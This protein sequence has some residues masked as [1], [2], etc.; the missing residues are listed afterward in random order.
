MAEKTL[1]QTEADA[2]HRLAA[3]LN[4]VAGAYN[5]VAQAVSAG[6]TTTAATAASTSFYDPR[7][8][9]SNP[10]RDQLGN[11]AGVE[12]HNFI[13][14]G[15]PSAGSRTG[16]GTLTLQSAFSDGIAYAP[17]GAIG[18]PPQHTGPF[19]NIIGVFLHGVFI[20]GRVQGFRD[21]Y[22]IV[23][24]DGAILWAVKT[25][26]V[27]KFSGL[28]HGAIGGDAGATVGGPG[29]LGGFT[30]V[31]RP[32]NAGFNGV[33][34]PAPAPPP[35][36]GGSGGGSGSGLNNQNL[37]SLATDSSLSLA[38]LKSINNGINVMAAKVNGVDLGLALRT[39]AT[40]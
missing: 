5:A 24:L 16:G 19:E 28:N 29:G 13:N 8:D 1:L 18:G 10:Q 21:D 35:P 30:P 4:K 15:T 17:P 14:R 39:G 31:G 34:L 26:A 23:G 7:V 11:D 25:G 37:Q 38:L 32:N 3:G 27:H 40:G 20:P 22:Q 9:P 2:A 36:N 6:A 12:G 33:P